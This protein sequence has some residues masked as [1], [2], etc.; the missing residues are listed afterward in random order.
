MRDNATDRI[1]IHIRA[2]NALFRCGHR[3][4]VTKILRP[5]CALGKEDRHLSIDMFVMVIKS[6]TGS[7]QNGRG[8]FIE[9]FRAAKLMNL[10]GIY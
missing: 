8:R 4:W 5:V 3:Q 2:C 6:P 1:I 10:A 9:N 7:E